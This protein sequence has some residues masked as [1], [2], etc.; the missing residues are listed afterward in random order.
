MDLAGVIQNT[1]EPPGDY[2]VSMPFY[3][4]DGL[5]VLYARGD[6]A[7]SDLYKIN[8]DGSG[9]TAI[10]QASGVQEYYPINIDDQQ[11]LFSRWVSDTDHTDQI[12]V[13]PIV[14]R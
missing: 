5:S 6:G 11:Y 12:Y 4:A 2:E 9:N 8:T 14:I 10:Q 13:I 3:T 7:S 1:I